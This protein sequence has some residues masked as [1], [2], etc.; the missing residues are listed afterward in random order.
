[1]VDA[2][3]LVCQIGASAQFSLLVELRLTIAIDHDIELHCC[4]CLFFTEI[5]ELTAHIAEFARNYSRSVQKGKNLGRRRHA[6]Y[7]E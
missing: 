7:A 5:Y 3:S 2:G 4:I 6:R 1:M